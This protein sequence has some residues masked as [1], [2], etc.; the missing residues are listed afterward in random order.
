MKLII[1]LIFLLLTNCKT[2][3]YKLIGITSKIEEIFYY[4]KDFSV[5]AWNIDE[6]RLN[7]VRLEIKNSIAMQKLDNPKEKWKEISE[8]ATKDGNYIL[9]QIFPETRI[10]SEFLSFQ[11]Q[12]NDFSPLKQYSYYN[13]I[14]ET[15]IRTRYYNTPG[16]FYMGGFYGTSRGFIYSMSARPIEQDLNQKLTHS[17]NFLI[18]FSK[19][20]L[21]K[22]NR[23]RVIT[24]NGNFID[25]EFNN[26]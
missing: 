6:E 20:N 18:L 19:E 13:E 10:P 11:F 7:K 16:A 23:F 4:G 8:I 22:E 5:S 25:F 1:T 14:I 26:P 2:N 24:P 12:L 9:F 21:K 17:Y 3:E 15:N